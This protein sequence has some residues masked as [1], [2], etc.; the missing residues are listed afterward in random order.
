MYTL[1][2]YLSDIIFLVVKIVEYREIV[3]PYV[4]FSFSLASLL[5]KIYPLNRFN[6]SR[7][8]FFNMYS[9]PANIFQFNY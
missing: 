5:V 3:S 2:Y 4:L 8:T 1:P 9:P 7:D 6:V